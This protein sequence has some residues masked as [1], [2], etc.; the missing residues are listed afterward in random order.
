MTSPAQ[1]SRA[2]V[3]PESEGVAPHP[4]T[5]DD[6]Q[7]LGEFRRAIRQFLAFSEEGAR[8]H[9]LT[10]QQHQALL[11]IKAH[12]GPD[13]I[14]IGDLAECLLIKNHSAVELVA[15]LVERDLV[16]RRDDEADRRRVVLALRP[17]GADIL[18]TISRRNLGRLRQG[19]DILAE[20]IEAAHRA[21]P[22]AP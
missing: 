16:S 22:A 9:G 18:E 10:S 12:R 20:I 4:L 3:D 6:Y 1:P 19:A 11:A 8:A 2:N 14:S 5:A 13:P 7:A 21:A 15:R 17:R